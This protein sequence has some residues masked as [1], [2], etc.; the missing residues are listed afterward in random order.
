MKQSLIN[1]LTRFIT[2]FFALLICALLLYITC[3]IVQPRIDGREE[4]EDNL[5]RLEVLPLADEFSRM[6]DIELLEG[7]RDVYAAA[8]E[9]GFVVTVEKKTVNANI[10]VMT[11]LDPSGGVKLVKVIDQGDGTPSEEGARDYAYYYTSASNARFG[12]EARAMRLV[13]Q[14]GQKS[15]SAADVLSAIAT[16]K[17]QLDVIEESGGEF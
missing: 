16:S 15:Y 4:A 12:S 8:N 2:L 5:S 1:A 6:E 17:A 10:T 9:S 13:N 14:L 7:V 3:I 11:G